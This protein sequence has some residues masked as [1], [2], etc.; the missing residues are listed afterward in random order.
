MIL[1][2]CFSNKETTFRVSTILFTLQIQD[3]F[4]ELHA[5]TQLAFFAQM[6]TRPIVFSAIPFLQRDQS[7]KMVFAYQRPPQAF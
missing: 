7:Y 6:Q 4:K 1:S 2:F 3:L 5:L